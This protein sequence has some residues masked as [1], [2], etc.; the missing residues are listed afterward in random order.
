M[1]GRCRKL[2]EKKY[3]LKPESEL[4]LFRCLNGW[5][6]RCQNLKTFWEIYPI[7]YFYEIFNFPIQNDCS[8]AHLKRFQIS[9]PTDL[10][11]HQPLPLKFTISPFFL[12][13]FYSLK[14]PKIS[15][16]F[17]PP[18]HQLPN[19]NKST[20]FVFLSLSLIHSNNLRLFFPTAVI[21][22]RD[23]PTDQQKLTN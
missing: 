2:K 22:M 9:F 4:R 18:R 17:S 6:R 23:R 13:L 7:S 10:Q 11:D 14:Y 16:K 8:V 20:R 1:C 5:S 3:L 12:P 15:T 21:Y 19:F